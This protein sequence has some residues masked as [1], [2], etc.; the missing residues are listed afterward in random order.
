M[1]ILGKAGRLAAM[2]DLKTLA[3]LVALKRLARKRPAVTAATGDISDALGADM[4][5]MHAVGGHL[6]AL[7]GAERFRLIVAGDG[8]LAAKDEELGVKIMAVIV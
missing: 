8:D 4:L 6:T 7:P 5:G 3:A 1:H 2:N